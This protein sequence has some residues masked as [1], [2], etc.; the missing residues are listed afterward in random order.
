MSALTT[1]Q[2]WTE[3]LSVARIYARPLISYSETSQYIRS[4][5]RLE[6]EQSHSG[7]LPLV[8]IEDTEKD[9]EAKRAKGPR[10]KFKRVAKA[11]ARMLAIHRSKKKQDGSAPA[12]GFED[13]P[14][15][16]TSSAA[17]NVTKA[18]P[19]GGTAV[20][21][22]QVAMDVATDPEK[23]LLR[24]LQEIRKDKAASEQANDTTAAVQRGAQNFEKGP[25]G[26]EKDA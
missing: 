1:V 25:K 3:V 7:L 9:L 17:R 23:A 10:G 14:S 21:K 4:G 8:A 19:K 5:S 20:E 16:S 2:M 26:P 15:A 13:A 24:L 11:G 18:L 12:P 6:P 22:A